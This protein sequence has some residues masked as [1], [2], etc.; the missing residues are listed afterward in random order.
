MLAGFVLG[1][2][3]F[4]RSLRQGLRI[5]EREQRQAR[6]LARPVSWPEIV[7]ALEQARGEKWDDFSMRYGDWGLDEE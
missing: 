5:K 7:S 6:K 2:E 4:A 3:S 1:T